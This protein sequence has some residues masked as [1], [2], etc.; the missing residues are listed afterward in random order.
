MRVRVMS[1]MKAIAH[2][3]LQEIPTCVIVSI[4]GAKDHTPY[5]YSRQGTKVK[6]VYGM[7]FEDIDRE[8]E[9]YKACQKSDFDGLKDFIDMWKDE[10]EEIIVH[11]HAGISRS[12]GC[13]AAIC[14]Y[15]QIDDSFIWD[16]DRKSVV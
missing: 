15:I 8:I 14:Q 2:S 1:E 12:S 10:V 6:A 13:A 3:Y 5:F 16:R 9:G 7:H 4:T 11:C